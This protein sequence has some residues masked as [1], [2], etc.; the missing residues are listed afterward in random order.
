MALV[1]IKS[2]DQIDRENAEKA[3]VRLQNERSSS[4]QPQAV[5][6][7]ANHVRKCWEVAKQNRAKINGRLLNCLRRRK[8]EYSDEKLAAIKQMGGSEIYMLIT[9]AKCRSAKAWLGDLFSP[10]GDRPFT[11][12]PTPI[13]DM[14]VSIKSKLIAEAMRGAQELGVTPDQIKPLLMKHRDRILGELKREAEDRADKMAVAI[15]D[16]LLDADWRTAFDEFLD[17]LV[18]YPVAVMKGVEFRYA[19]TLKWVNG[20]DGFHAESAV[21][22]APKVRRVSPFRAYPSPSSGSSLEGHWF[23][24]HHTLTRSDLAAMRGAP[25]YNSEGIAKALLH[26]GQGGLRE[27]LWTETERASLEGRSYIWASSED[28]DAIEWSG[29]LQGQTLLD[30]G[31]SADDIDDPLEEYSVSVMTIGNY[32]IRALVNPDPAGKQDYFSACWQTVPGSFWGIALPET[33][34][35][36]E[37]ACNAAARALINNMGFAS[38]PQV[39]VEMDRIAPGADVNSIFPWKVWKSNSSQGASSGQGVGFFQPQSNATELMSIYERFN[40]YA[41]EIS[42]MPSYAHG[43]DTGAG[44]AKTA[45]GLSMLMNAASKTIKQVV[46]SVDIGVIEP[47]VEKCYNHL[48]LNSEDESIKGDLVPKARGSESLVHKEQ[49]QLRQQELL[50]ITSNEFD[51][52]IIGKDGRR[53]MLAEVLKTGDIPVD[54]IL[55]SRE[56]LKEMQMAEMQAQKRMANV[57]QQH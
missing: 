48:M 52:S 41:D 2:N 21:K 18:T 28:I 25:G 47:L 19:K 6:N 45:S 10:A 39:W 38:G 50:G 35:D 53:E 16:F 42:G 44:A 54:R 31:M 49:A 40:R 5:D 27:W 43:S 32:V 36:C 13:A 3:E 56:E 17:D 51:M 1:A 22:I 37:D 12:E 23:I 14:P 26:Y 4:A 33:L 15:E 55:P 8:G 24:E 57:P 11:L 34:S 30:F 46:R 7:L 9:A 29:S 20:S